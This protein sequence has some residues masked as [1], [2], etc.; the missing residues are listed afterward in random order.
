M[1][2]E[3]LTHE[4]EKEL[5]HRYLGGDL[6]GRDRIILCHQ[7]LLRKI[8]AQFRWYPVEFEDL[9][10]EG[11]MA[12]IRVFTSFNPDRGRFSGF[13]QSHAKYAMQQF[14]LANNWQ[15]KRLTTKAHLAVFRH[16]H[17]GKTDEQLAEDLDLSV[18]EVKDTKLRLL[19]EMSLDMPSEETIDFPDDRY[20]PEHI[21]EKNDL[22]MKT[23][24]TIDSLPDREREIIS[25]RWL[26]ETPATLDALG[27]KHGVSLERVRQVE[28]AA[29][30]K[31]R[32][33][34]L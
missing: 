7:P 21:I 1:V 11:N 4:Q 14:V 31:M 25:S 33:C 28:K 26:T 34:L 6:T 3:L 16:L 32:E 12:L 2:N 30:T 17:E 10:Q 9:M 22:L 18:E 15:V 29:F 20:C 27:K 8:A 23:F 5:Y 24:H 13:A 19:G